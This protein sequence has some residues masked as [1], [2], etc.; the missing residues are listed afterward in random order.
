VGL[1]HGTRAARQAP[2][3]PPRPIAWGSAQAQAARQRKPPTR[4]RAS[5]PHQASSATR[6]RKPPTRATRRARASP[7]HQASSASPQWAAAGWRWVHQGQPP[8]GQQ[9]QPPGPPRATASHQAPRRRMWHQGNAFRV[10][11]P[12]R[13]PASTCPCLPSRRAAT[14][15]RHQPPQHSITRTLHRPLLGAAPW[16]WQHPASSTRRRAENKK[17]SINISYEEIFLI[18]SQLV[19]KMFPICSQNY[20]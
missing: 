3:Q 19:P 1:W 16:P 7:P 8:P 2:Q 18:C 15:Q 6:Q 17:K 14:G 13:P 5:P 20:L 10:T 9:C 11:F 12:P 4:A